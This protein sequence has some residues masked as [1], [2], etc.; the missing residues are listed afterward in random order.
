MLNSVRAILRLGRSGIDELSW[1]ES[2]QS[3][4]GTEFGGESV[5]RSS[6]LVSPWVE[7]DVGLIHLLFAKGEVI[8]HFGVLLGGIEQ[9]GLVSVHSPQ[10]GI[11]PSITTVLDLDQLL[12]LR[13]G[14]LESWGLL[15]WDCHWSCINPCWVN[16]LTLFFIFNFLWCLDSSWTYRIFGVFI[17]MTSKI[18]GGLTFLTSKIFGGDLRNFWRSVWLLTLSILGDSGRF[19]SITLVLWDVSVE[20]LK[21]WSVVCLSGELSLPPMIIVGGKEL[22]NFVTSFENRL[23]ILKVG[24]VRSKDV[25]PIPFNLLFVFSLE[26]LI[27]PLVIIYTWR[28]VLSFLF[29]HSGLEFRI[30]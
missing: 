20:S 9:D 26:V 18:F 3:G 2:V 30:N 1:V 17:I 6:V 28:C 11:V 15:A 13:V 14:E 10:N 7:G 16:L 29:W 19:G 25:D 8:Q 5:N 12:L 4:L 21:H 22:C 27:D 24:L 23:L